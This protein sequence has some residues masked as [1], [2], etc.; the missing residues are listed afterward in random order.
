[1]KYTLLS[2]WSLMLILI[3]G[4][5]LAQENN[6]ITIGQFQKFESRTLNSDAYFMVSIPEDASAESE[7]PVLYLLDGESHF[8]NAIA[9]VKKFGGDVIPK[10]VIVGV[11]STNRQSDLQMRPENKFDDYL[12]KDLI[13]HIKSNYPVSDYCVLFGHSLG[14]IFALDLIK[15]HPSA[16]QSCIVLEPSLS[17]DGSNERSNYLVEAFQNHH[18]PSIRLGIA[19]S[20]N[21]LG[22]LNQLLRDT[23]RNTLHMRTLVEFDQQM[24]SAVNANYDSFYLE[25]ED[26]FSCTHS[27]LYLGLKSLFHSYKIPEQ[28]WQ[29]ESESGLLIKEH[30]EKLK[31]AYQYDVK[32]EE[33][34]LNNLA[35]YLFGLGDTQDAETLLR[36]NTEYHPNSFSVYENI[37]NFYAATGNNQKAIAAFKEALLVNDS[38]EVKEKI[39]VLEKELD[40]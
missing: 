30:F 2:I 19:N 38:L 14:G 24:N 40:E 5:V 1:M 16:F 25:N 11:I 26:H 8:Y 9:I 32:P 23:S 28:V 39:E 17:I 4:E 33:N 37:G 7:Y 34:F 36:L 29:K 35:F 10:L 15:N 6:E 3:V 27:G 21:I 31:A 22:E 18:S 20:L 12:V 13:P